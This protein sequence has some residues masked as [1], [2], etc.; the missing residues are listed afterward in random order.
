MRVRGA[1]CTGEIIRARANGFP[2]RQEFV[3]NN[4]SAD[5]LSASWSSS[6]SL[7]RHCLRFYGAEEL[8]QYLGPL[9]FTQCF[10]LDIPSQVQVSLTCL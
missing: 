4:R 2:S 1:V 8:C 3:G 7:M 6:F 10:A 5:S 9:Y